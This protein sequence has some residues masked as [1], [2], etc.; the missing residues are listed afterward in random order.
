M[1]F[2]ARS[3]SLARL[4]RH[5]LPKLPLRLVSQRHVEVEVDVAGHGTQ[6]GRDGL[7][8]G[9]FRRMGWRETV[10]EHADAHEHAPELGLEVQDPSWSRLLDPVRGEAA[11]DLLLLGHGIVEQGGRL[12]RR[13]HVLGACG[14]S[15]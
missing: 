15:S 13:V 6:S 7:D 9:G 1:A 4:F 2:A 12:L 5:F 3:L 11:R 8:E 10:Q 14:S